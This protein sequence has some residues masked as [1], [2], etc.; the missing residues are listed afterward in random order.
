M[1][2]VSVLVIAETLTEYGE[3][4]LKHLLA[5]PEDIEIVFVPDL[6]LDGLDERIMVVPS[7]A[8]AIAGVK[9]QLAL[10]NATGD[11]VA[12]ID[13]DAYPHPSWLTVAL[14]ALEGDATLAAVV[15]PNLTPPSDSPAQHL[16]GAV[17]ASWLVSGPD[18]FA[19]AIDRERDVHDSPG[20]NIVIR[21]A[22]AAE[23]GF[24]PIFGEDTWFFE[25]LSQ[26][27][28]RVRYIPTAIVYHSRRPLWR[29]HLRQ[30]YRWS[31]ARSASAREARG[32]SRR[33]A[34]FAPS[35]LLLFLLSGP[36]VRG[37]AHRV[38]RFGAS[39]YAVA[40]VAAGA[41]RS[42]SRWVRLSAAIAATH[43]TYG[44]GFLQGMLGAPRPAEGRQEIDTA[45][46]AGPR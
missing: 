21:R 32:I 46:G 29:R 37:R 42:P 6:P 24:S 36:F 5:L 15:G 10:E 39:T 7:G 30:L 40:C 9:R 34:Y 11:V 1:T 38:W 3:R 35:A 4:C 25:G 41:D 13:D 12:L 14:S 43:L 16:S 45:P 28:A 8:G 18:R 26:I 20:A 23:V 31:R 17:Y 44:F 2:R 22:A 33:P 19:Y 27:G